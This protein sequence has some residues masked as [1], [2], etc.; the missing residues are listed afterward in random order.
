MS[1]EALCPDCVASELGELEKLVVGVLDTIGDAAE[2]HPEPIITKLNHLQRELHGLQD[3][4]M[5]GGLCGV[6]ARR[7]N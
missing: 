7:R 6:M 5:H 1:I 3:S 4:L 2:D